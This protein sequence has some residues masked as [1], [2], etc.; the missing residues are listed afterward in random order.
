MISV[1]RI[2]SLRA[3]ITNTDVTW[4]APETVL[5]SLGEV[6]CAIICVCVPTLRPLVTRSHEPRKGSYEVKQGTESN[7][8]SG[9]LKRPRSYGFDPLEAQPSAQSPANFDDEL[10]RGGV[11]LDTMIQKPSICYLPHCGAESGN[12]NVA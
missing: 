12:L 7:G 9:R 10:L 6:S 4:T 11:C 5:W 2:T 1:V 3:S 8:S